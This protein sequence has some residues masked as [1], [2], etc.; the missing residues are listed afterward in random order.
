MEQRELDIWWSSLPIEEKE[1]IARK[2]LTKTGED[3]SQA[4]YPACSAWWNRL[5]HEQQVQIYTHCVAKHGDEV[6][7][8]NEGNPYGD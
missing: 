2:G 8:W 5:S 7:Q 3:P 4:T 1:R 6:R